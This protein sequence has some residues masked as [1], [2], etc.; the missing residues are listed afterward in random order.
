MRVLVLGLSASHLHGLF[1]DLHAPDADILRPLAAPLSGSPPTWMPGWCVGCCAV[2]AVALRARDAARIREAEATAAD[3]DARAGIAR[4]RIAILEAE[5]EAGAAARRQ[6]E[7][8]QQAQQVLFY[9]FLLYFVI[10]NDCF[11]PFPHGRSMRA[12]GAAAA[13]A[14]AD[15]LAAQ[16]AASRAQAGSADAE[17]AETEAAFHLLQAEARPG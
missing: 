2:Q 6:L 17:A 13:Q 9:I 11:F 12:E 14:R 5:L 1:A 10:N 15:A 7:A 8:D 3:L 16:L 4:Q